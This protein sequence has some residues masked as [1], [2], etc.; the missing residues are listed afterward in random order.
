L[1]N[2]LGWRFGASLLFI[3]LN[4]GCGG[5]ADEPMPAGVDVGD[6]PA[7]PSPSATPS[8]SPTPSPPATPSA[9]EYANCARVPAAARQ[10]G[11]RQVRDFGALPDDNR[12][13]SD[14]IQRALDA[15]KAGETLVFSPGRYLISRTV[16]V[17]EPGVTITGPGA[18]IHATNPDDQALRIEADNTTVSS[19]TFTAVTDGRRTAPWHS[20]IVVSASLGGGDYR[21]VYNTVIRD[22][23]IVNAGEAGGPSAN[24]SSAGG[25][26]LMRANGFLVSGNTIK[27][28]LA[29]GIHVTAGS[30]NGRILNNTVRETG[31]DMI[32]V[33]SYLGSGNPAGDSAKAVLASWRTRVD[34][35]L[36]RN[37]LVAGNQLS[38]QYWGRGITV[39]GGQSI[40]IAKNT[41]DN[42]PRGAGV[43][44]AREASY[45]TFGVENVL[46]EGNLIRDVQTLE[47]PYDYEDKF[48]SS[49]RT[50]HGAVEIHAALFEDEAASDLRESLSV[51]N[52]LVRA[53]V[54]ERASVSG[55][56]AGVD[57][58]Q[59]ISGT[60]SSG[61]SLERRTVTGIVRN[62]GVTNNRFNHVTGEAL[63]VLS[64]DLMASG[65]FCSANQ[66]D[67]S[68]Y[69]ASACKQASEP[70]ARGAPLKCTV[71]GELSL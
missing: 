70:A 5:S 41:I 60:D 22:N 15:M 58:A 21:T 42:V 23:R 14:A 26:M 59:T 4:A 49:S 6:A 55:L 31:D 11:L 20:R 8:P 66:R 57:M 48:A 3:L 16:R 54:V 69:K 53:N 37:V 36:V 62:V 1:A 32:A 44:M 19:L 7:A 65:V 13:D 28:T 39:V 35:S 67:G 64:P 61:R 40:T 12:D 71:D 30:K 9:S 34:N 50:G 52:V 29:D 25:I 10:A 51:S 18:T 17:R 56:R 38:G 68:S 43:L 2:A 46:V 47:P 27:R 33:V 24:S 63:R 45:E